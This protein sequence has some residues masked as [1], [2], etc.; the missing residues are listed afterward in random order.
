MAAKCLPGREEKGER[1]AFDHPGFALLSA[2][3]PGLLA[4]LRLVR[5]AGW[6][7]GVTILLVVHALAAA[8]AV[9]FVHGVGIYGSTC[10]IPLL[11]QTVS[12]CDAIGS[13]FLLLPAVFMR[14]G[15]SPHG[16]EDPAG[17]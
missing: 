15:G 11:V 9:S 16:P 10:L 3:I 4:C 13:G 14:R 2:F 8:Y 5:S 12:G 6:L 7:S 1:P 17:V